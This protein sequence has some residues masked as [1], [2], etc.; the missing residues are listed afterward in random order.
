VS[1]PGNL[2][3]DLAVPDLDPADAAAVRKLV[4]RHARGDAAELLAMLGVAESQRRVSEAP[5]RPGVCPVCGWL[6]SGR[7]HRR[8]C[9][10]RQQPKPMRKYYRHG[11]SA[12]YKYG[13]KCRVCLKAVREYSD[14]RRAAKAAAGG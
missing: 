6:L 11:R 9:G 13:C 5:P 3:T 7:A 8:I 2:L 12:Y 4:G 14:R 1:G 10:T